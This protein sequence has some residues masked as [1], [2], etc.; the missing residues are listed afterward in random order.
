VFTHRSLNIFSPVLLTLIEKNEQPEAWGLGGIPDHLEASLL[1][2][3]QG[4]V[5]VMNLRKCI[6]CG[7]QAMLADRCMRCGF[8]SSGEVAATIGYTHPAISA[9]IHLQAHRHLKRKRRAEV[10]KLRNEAISERE[11]HDRFQGALYMVAAVLFGLYF[12]SRAAGWL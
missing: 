4:Q 11:N 3:T 2:S 8:P 12:I 6:H 5:S 1:V 7:H 10:L 9:S